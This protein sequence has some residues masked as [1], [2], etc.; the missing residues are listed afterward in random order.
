M[1]LAD[2]KT[3]QITPRTVLHAVERY[4][5]LLL[6]VQTLVYH[7][8]RDICYVVPVELYY[9]VMSQSP[10]KVHLQRISTLF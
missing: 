10:V 8:F 2:K 1:T 3:T 9:V 7:D 5:E 4:R 6:H